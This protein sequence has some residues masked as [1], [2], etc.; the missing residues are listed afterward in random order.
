MPGI[1]EALAM[2][3]VTDDTDGESVQI[4]PGIALCSRAVGI[5][6]C[7]STWARCGG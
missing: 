1:H 4:E 7:S 6:R 5:V 2:S 3:P